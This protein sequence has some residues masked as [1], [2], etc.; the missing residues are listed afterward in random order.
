MP[1]AAVEATWHAG[2]G[3]YTHFLIKM[4]CALCFICREHAWAHADRM[5]AGREVG[6]L[7]ACRKH[8]GGYWVDSR[9]QRASGCKTGNEAKRWEQ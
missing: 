7:P 3:K 8:G 6:P 9:G 1:P 5:K 4:T 2:A